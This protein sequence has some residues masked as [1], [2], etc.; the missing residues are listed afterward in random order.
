MIALM[1]CCFVYLDDGWQGSIELGGRLFP[2]NTKN[3]EGN[4]ESVMI[5]R[6]IGRIFILSLYAIEDGLF[7]RSF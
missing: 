4:L 2:I 6:N 3:L 1:T 7:Y 5:F